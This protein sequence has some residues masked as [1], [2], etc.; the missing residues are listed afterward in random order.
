MAPPNHIWRTFL[1]KD[2][3]DTVTYLKIEP[4]NEDHLLT[5]AVGLLLGTLIEVGIL[6]A[7]KDRLTRGEHLLSWIACMG[8][9]LA[10]VKTLWRAIEIK[11]TLQGNAEIQHIL[12]VL[13]LK[14]DLE[15]SNIEP[16]NEALVKKILTIELAEYCEAHHPRKS[17]GIIIRN[18]I[19]VMPQAKSPTLTET[20][21]PKTREVR[22]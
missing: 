14:P 2:I 15:L 22:S 4:V 6:I 19:G 7:T 20:S 21:K 13:E 16:L 8:I 1:K 18:K 17:W 3:P 12:E 10:A 5:G 11:I 9:S